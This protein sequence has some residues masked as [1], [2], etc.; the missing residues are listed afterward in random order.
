MPRRIKKAKI[1]FISLVPRGANKL[2][3]I[4]KEDG[5]F[6]VQLLAKGMTEQGELTAVVYAP[7][8]R[9]S[10]G[11]IASAAVIKDM[12]YSAAKEGLEI[13]IR[14]DGKALG[15]DQVYVAEQF[16]VQKGD[17]RFEGLTDYDGNPVDPT[18]GWGVVIKID[19]PSLRKLY[20][21]GKWAGVSMGGVAEVE[22]EKED[23][24]A[25]DRI[26][27]ALEKKLNNKESSMTDEQIQNLAKATAEATATAVVAALK[28][29]KPEPAPAPTPEP[30]PDARPV[31]K[32][33]PT[34]PE[35]VKAHRD[36]LKKHDLQQRLAKAGSPAEVDAILKELTDAEGESPADPQLAS[37]Q[38]ELEK[39]Q[40]KLR[41][42]QGRSNQP[43]PRGDTSNH[44]E[45]S[46]TFLNVSK[47]EQQ[48][49]G[50]GSKMAAWA[51]AQRGYNA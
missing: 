46:S 45:G 11:D 4:F 44:T 48:L 30:K 6:D 16:L 21:E 27:A 47:D 7:E 22:Q 23:M 38:A 15:R 34:N 20:A 32:G 40:A 5:S 12:L 13:D 42:L 25:A 49:A 18:G 28:A 31:F 36:A 1:K 50:L 14:H 17:P 9:D 41:K 8:L 2:P 51:N 29:D 24:S 10:Q 3:T 37:A 26:A 43:A 35:D 39:A 19:D 33:D